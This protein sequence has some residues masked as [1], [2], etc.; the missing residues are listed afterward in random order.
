MRLVRIEPY[1]LVE[2]TSTQ[3]VLPAARHWRHFEQT[4]DE[5]AYRIA[6]EYQP[7]P[8]WR[9]LV[10]RLLVRRAVERMLRV[11]MANL[12]RRFAEVIW[13]ADSASAFLS[14]NTIDAQAT[15]AQDGAWLRATGPIGCTHG[16][17]VLIRVTV[18]QA[19]TGARARKSWKHRCT[20]ELQPWQIR[21]RT[22]HG[23][24]F[25]TGAGTVCAVA[26]TRSAT[27]VTDGRN[28]CEPVFVSPVF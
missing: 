10:D 22:R 12:E 26:K 7:R 1:R 3:R 20:G 4:G 2:Y 15:Y 18:T 8:G 13:G 9:S 28:W 19:T 27:H 5:L 16:E 14:A 17:R 25:Q 6:V 23:T 21:A 24:H 11:T